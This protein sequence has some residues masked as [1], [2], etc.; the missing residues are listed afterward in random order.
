ME[1][2]KEVRPGLEVSSLG[3]VRKYLTGHDDGDGYLAISGGKRGSKWWAGR[4]RVGQ[5]GRAV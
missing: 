3:R 1:V 2:W 4:R 5:R